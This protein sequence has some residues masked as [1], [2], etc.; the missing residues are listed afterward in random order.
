MLTTYHE[1]SL[2]IA[3]HREERVHPHSMHGFDHIMGMTMHSIKHA[4]YTKSP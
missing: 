4:R 3:Y 1:T 2:V